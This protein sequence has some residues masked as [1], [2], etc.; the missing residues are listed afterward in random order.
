MK[1]LIEKSAP[2]FADYPEAEVFHVTKD[3]QFFTEDGISHA[4]NHESAKNRKDGWP[5]KIERKDVSKKAIDAVLAERK[6]PVKSDEAEAK[7]KAEEEAAKKKAE[8]EAAAKKKAEEE[9]AKKK[10]QEEAE[11]KKKAEE[12]A[13]NK[14]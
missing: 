10:A 12:E 7:K 2:Y 1:E 4:R 6:K 14:K 13:T 8:E 3:G 11:A 5:K 9:A